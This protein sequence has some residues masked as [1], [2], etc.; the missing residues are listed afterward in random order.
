LGRGGASGGERLTRR[1][2]LAL[3]STALAWPLAARA[4]Q[5][6]MPVAGILSARGKD[7]N[8]QFLAAFHQALVEGGYVEGRNVAIEARWADGHYDRLPTLAADLGRRGVAVIFAA[9]G[10]V[11]VRAAQ[12]A[13][14]TIPIVST[15]G[16]NPVADG[17]AASIA[18]PGGNFTGVSL[19][20]ILKGEKPG[21]LPVVQP[22]RFELVLNLKA[23]KAIGLAVPPTILIAAD[24]VIE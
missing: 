11:S 10:R 1:A 22:T 24:E 15:F 17:F 7:D 9:G 2:T 16:A 21:D 19:L 8:P 4:Q 13:T 23:A 6:S 14:S 12:A 20:S 5:S 18:H 3:L